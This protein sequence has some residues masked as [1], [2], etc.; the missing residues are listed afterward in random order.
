V[1]SYATRQIASFDFVRY[2]L[3]VQNLLWQQTA[4][5]PLIKAYVIRASVSPSFVGAPSG[6]A[7]LPSNRDPHGGFF[8]D[9]LLL[10]GPPA[11]AG[12]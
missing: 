5:V 2:I 7:G 4:C 12:L 10:S 11:E 6:R 9:Y 8:P 3:Y 1:I